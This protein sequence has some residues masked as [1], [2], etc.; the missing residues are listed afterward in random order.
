MQR[1]RFGILGTGNIARQ[2]A[3]GVLASERCSVTAVGSRDPGAATAFCKS[4]GIDAVA[5][6]YDDLIAA[7]ACDAIYNALPNTLHHQWTIAALQA[8][9]HVLC[10]KPIA[11]TADEAREMFDAADRCGRVLIEAFMYR[12][13]PQTG[14]LIELLRGGAVGRIKLIRSSFCFR[15]RKT[16]NNIRFDASLAGG[17]LMDVGCYCINFSRLIAGGEPTGL[18][19]IGHQHAGGVDEQVSVLMNFPGDVQASFTAGMGVQADNTASVCGDEGYLTLAWPW[20]PPPG[21]AQIIVCG[22]APPR[23]DGGPTAAPPPVVH[24]IDEPRPLYGIEADAFAAAVLDGAA[25]FVSPAD[26]LGNMRILDTLRQKLD[27]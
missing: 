17:V 21:E 13:H 26:S 8:G 3:A 18:H 2:F 5:G 1:L 23:Q 4:L 16:E 7:P 11:V 9:K 10:E 20:K 12:A 14:Q 25:P 15:V 24:A 22:S 27:V 6:S 19:I